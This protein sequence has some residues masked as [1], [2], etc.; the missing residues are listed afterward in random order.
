M[1]S[2]GS[3][4]SPTFWQG[5]FVAFVCGLTAALALPALTMVVGTWFATKIVVLV[6]AT[7]Y[8]TYLIKVSNSRQGIVFAAG[9]WS[10]A[11]TVLLFFSASALSLGVVLL[12][13][14][15]GYWLSFALGSLYDT[16]LFRMPFV[17]QPSS[18]AVTVILG[19]AF[20]LSAHLPVQRA[21]N[22]MDWLTA[23][24]VKE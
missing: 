19:L 4:D 15:L 13:L 6:I 5:V 17:I 3:G 18:W 7:G 10:I 20:T 24:S 2:N 9:G 8:I 21:I 23:L 1:T 22:K 14:P 16:E 12:G 11:S